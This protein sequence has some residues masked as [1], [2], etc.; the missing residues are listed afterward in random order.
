MFGQYQVVASIARG[1]TSRV[2]LAVHVATGARVAVKA[3]MPELAAHPGMRTRLHGERALVGCVP[4]EG[5]VEM[6][7]A[8]VADDGTPYLVMEYLEG[9]PLGALVGDGPMDVPMALTITS[10]VAAA[11]AALHEAGV[12]HCDVKHDNVMVLDERVDG[13]P[14][15]KLVDFGVSRRVPLRLARGSLSGMKRDDGEDVADGGEGDHGEDDDA[16]TEIA[17]TPWCMAPEQWRG[18]PVPASDVYSLGCMLFDLLTGAPPFLGSVP[19]L[20][21]AHL[22][23]DPPRPAWLATMPAALERLL[24]A[25]LAKT[26]RQRPSMADVAA[27]LDDLLSEALD[28]AFGRAGDSRSTLDLRAA[29]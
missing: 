28:L 23:C 12:V 8:A 24:L 4:H 17:G 26:A 14:R 19:E 15:V 18:R 16:S 21:T 13:L 6:F 5:V 1:G 27:E 10:Q 2:M 7:E 20:M 9:Q 29:S 25:M 11:L 22:E 3:L